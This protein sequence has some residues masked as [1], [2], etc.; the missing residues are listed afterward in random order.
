MTATPLN[1]TPLFRDPDRSNAWKNPWGCAKGAEK[2][3]C[4]EAVVLTGCF[5]RV[6]FFSAPLRFSGVLRA[7]LKGAEKKRTLQKHPFGRPF[8]RATPSPL[9]RC[10]L[11]AP[12][13]T[14]NP[15]SVEIPILGFKFSFSINKSKSSIH[16]LLILQPERGRIARN[17]AR[18]QMS[19]RVKKKNTFFNPASRD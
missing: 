16:G 9:L 6:R 17:H 4:G 7:N 19:F 12:P 14:N 13:H 10:A 11:H 18:S 3:S 2:V 5:W 1:S 15:S 8:L